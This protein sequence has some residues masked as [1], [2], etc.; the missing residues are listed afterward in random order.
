MVFD[1]LSDLISGLQNVFWATG[2]DDELIRHTDIISLRTTVVSRMRLG[3]QE[4]AHVHAPRTPRLAPDLTD[5]LA[6]IR[7][8]ATEFSE[9]FL[10]TAQ[11]NE[12]TKLLNAFEYGFRKSDQA[13]G[14]RDLIP[15]FDQFSRAVGNPNFSRVEAMYSRWSED[16][17][18]HEYQV[19]L[20]HMWRCIRNRIEL[21]GEPLDPS[22]PNTIE[23]GASK[24]VNAYTV[25]A[26]IAS[27]VLFHDEDALIER[28]DCANDRFAA[29]VTAGVAGRVN[30]LAPFQAM[31][32]DPAID[33]VLVAS[34]TNSWN[35][36]ML[37]LSISGPALFCPELTFVLCLHEIAEFSDFLRL[38]HFSGVNATINEWIFDTFIAT[39]WG[40]ITTE[41]SLDVDSAAA[42]LRLVLFVPEDHG[43]AKDV[44]EKLENE[45][46]R[47][48]SNTNPLFYLD[49]L[50]GRLKKIIP[51]NLHIAELLRRGRPCT[52]ESIERVNIPSWTKS[53]L[54]AEGLI[55][56]AVDKHWREG[57]R[58]CL[59]ERLPDFAMCIGLRHMLN[60]PKVEEFKRHI[61]YLFVSLIESI[62]SS[63]HSEKHSD[64][65]SQLADRWA[66]QLCCF[67]DDSN[68]ERRRSSVIQQMKTACQTRRLPFSVDDWV[69]ECWTQSELFLLGTV[70]R[71]EKTDLA[72][73]LASARRGMRKLWRYM[74]HP[75][76]SSLI[77][78]FRELWNSA[79]T[80][81]DSTVKHQR[82]KTDQLRVRFLLSLWAKAQ[83]FCVR[84]AF[85]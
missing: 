11:S 16:R 63:G 56:S 5:K 28:T 58:T 49:D 1:T 67:S 20:Q 65:V 78:E 62:Y 57:Y 59:I 64:L 34:V 6:D 84:S 75:V 36:P 73:S 29:A 26:W 23:F 80:Q 61:N 83:K 33:E 66:F 55:A 72:S 22:F 41:S 18:N 68:V 37:L 8:G 15:F 79:I 38:D 4:N 50:I 82:V 25:A 46:R 12:L 10:T 60:Y 81:S 7:K 2:K 3:I 74:D 52:P 77:G 17:I 43:V 30:V 14:L 39:I 27:Y 31:Y 24:I 35:A 54:G 70:D 48:W 13:S 69:K 19:T 32:L 40:E 71:P 9:E 53:L 76:G 85:M 45:E 44:I 51:K 42:F 21:R 47:K